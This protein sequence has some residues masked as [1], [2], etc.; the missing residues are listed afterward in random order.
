MNNCE[1]RLIAMNNHDVE[2]HD[3]NDIRSLG[4]IQLGKLRE[5]EAMIPQFFF[6]KEPECMDQ[7]IMYNSS[8]FFY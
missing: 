2:R 5:A 8:I 6:V 4:K 3:T 7:S 1:H